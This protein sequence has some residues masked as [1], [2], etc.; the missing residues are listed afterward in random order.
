MAP[1]RRLQLPRA[2]VRKL[3]GSHCSVQLGGGWSALQRWACAARRWVAAREL[4][5]P[6]VGW[7]EPHTR[8]GTQ[9]DWAHNK[10][11][12]LWVLAAALHLE[13]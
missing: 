12:V 3:D 6:A 8:A 1:D 13:C 5:Q 4:G 9:Q 11:H 7:M 2:L 10:P